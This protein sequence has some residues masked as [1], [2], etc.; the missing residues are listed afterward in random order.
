MIN[1]S[2]LRNVVV[3]ISFMIEDGAAALL[4]HEDETEDS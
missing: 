2:P 1:P 3:A 4:I